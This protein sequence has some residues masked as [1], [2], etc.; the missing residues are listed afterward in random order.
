[1]WLKTET[2][3]VLNTLIYITF[4]KYSSQNGCK[5]GSS[6]LSWQCWSP[7]FLPQL[8]I[9]QILMVIV[10]LLSYPISILV[11]PPSCWL[12]DLFSSSCLLPRHFF[13]DI[14]AK[15]FK[16]RQTLGVFWTHRCIVN[17]E[18]AYGKFHQLYM[19]M[20]DKGEGS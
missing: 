13:P 18:T 11:S 2:Y 8:H 9:N 3:L 1:M 4:F 12:K 14:Q 16:A 19:R 6:N 20:F 7:E 17:T 5:Q 15:R 10:I